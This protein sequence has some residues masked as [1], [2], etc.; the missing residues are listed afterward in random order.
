MSELISTMIEVGIAIH[1]GGDPYHRLR[2]AKNQA[3]NGTPA[4]RMYEALLKE[5]RDYLTKA[6]DKARDCY[7]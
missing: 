3:T 5:N 1:G 7:P 2:I 4:R 6:A